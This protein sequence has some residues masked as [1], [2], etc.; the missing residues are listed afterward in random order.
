MH[1][2]LEWFHIKVVGIKAIWELHT[3]YYNNFLEV[4]IFLGRYELL[5]DYTVGTR[6][7]NSHLYFFF[8]L[9]SPFPFSPPSSPSSYSCDK[10]IIQIFS[11]QAVRTACKENIYTVED[12]EQAKMDCLLLHIMYQDKEQIAYFLA[13]R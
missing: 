2:H 3:L 1:L 6:N 7:L 8:S 12:W 13:G 11:L 10:E 9:S 5:H 4:P